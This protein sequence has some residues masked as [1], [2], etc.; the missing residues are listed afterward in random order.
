MTPFESAYYCGKRVQVYRA[1][2]SLDIGAMLVRKSHAVPFAGRALF[3]PATA[4][5]AL[6]DTALFV[7]PEHS[8]LPFEQMQFMYRLLTQHAEIQEC[9]IITTSA[10]ILTDACCFSHPNGTMYTQLAGASASCIDDW[11]LSES[12]H[13]LIESQSVVSTIL[14]LIGY[15]DQLQALWTLPSMRGD[16]TFLALLRE[17]NKGYRLWR[18][19]LHPITLERALRIMRACAEESKET[20]PTMAH[21]LRALEKHLGDGYY[22][23]EVRR[24][25]RALEETA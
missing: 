25:A 7:Y 16:S 1:N 4:Y 21:I 12:E 24:R 15:Y 23:F 9:M 5:H 8:L 17:L 20:H 13:R 14:D 3:P 2:T 22:Q 6:T 11:F 19:T 10:Y 18:V